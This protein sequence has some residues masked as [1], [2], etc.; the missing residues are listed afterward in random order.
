M[1]NKDKDIKIS[2]T[3]SSNYNVGDS[4]DILGLEGKFKVVGVKEVDGKLHYSIE[5]IKEV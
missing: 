4:I 2:S 1:D 3:E 5:P